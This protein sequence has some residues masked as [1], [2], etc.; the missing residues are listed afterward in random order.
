MKNL[1]NLRLFL[2]FLQ[3]P[4]LMKYQIRRKTLRM[5]KHRFW[6]EPKRKKK[7]KKLS[8][9]PYHLF[10]KK[11]KKITQRCPTE[12]KWPRKKENNI[13]LQILQ[14]KSRRNRTLKIRTVLLSNLNLSQKKIYSIM[15]I[16][17]KT[18]HQHRKLKNLIIRL[19]WPNFWINFKSKMKK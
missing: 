5:R 7:N 13:I 8:R 3:N 19:S 10:I 1:R 2:L 6:T 18:N 16:P 15:L 14:L 4:I 12:F 11:K 17:V 9:Q